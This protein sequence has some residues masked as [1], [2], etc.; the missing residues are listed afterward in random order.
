MEDH[1]Q[2]NKLQK[3][4]LIDQV[5]VETK[6]KVVK[7]AM[8]LVDQLVKQVNFLGV[9]V[10]LRLQMMVLPQAALVITAEEEVVEDHLR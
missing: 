1:R 7:V 2:L 9:A 4:I 6:N 3:Q 10:L 5:V 8:V